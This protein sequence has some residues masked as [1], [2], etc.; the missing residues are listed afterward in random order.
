MML[1]SENMQKTHSLLA[2]TGGLS[3]MAQVRCSAAGHP[4]D[5][6]ALQNIRLPPA[7]EWGQVCVEVRCQHDLSTSRPRLLTNQFTAC[8]AVNVSCCMREVVLPAG[9]YGINFRR[10]MLHCD[11][12]DSLQ[13]SVWSIRVL[14][15]VSDKSCRLV[16]SKNG[17]LVRR[18]PGSASVH[19]WPRLRGCSHTGEQARAYYG[20]TNRDFSGC[21]TSL[22]CWVFHTPRVTW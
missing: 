18:Q 7:L 20:G 9:G 10:L 15:G 3:P 22:S 21:L 8:T 5:V 14:Q 4:A 13:V 11:A 17:R 12:L 1:L 6:L 16:H 19:S 2:A